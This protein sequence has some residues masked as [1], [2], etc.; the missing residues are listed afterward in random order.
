MGLNVGSTDSFSNINTNCKEKK[1]SCFEEIVELLL[2][3]VKTLLAFKTISN[4][5]E[6]KKKLVYA[7]FVMKSVL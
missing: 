3:D 2:S 6:E 1:E 4:I 5:K 7:L